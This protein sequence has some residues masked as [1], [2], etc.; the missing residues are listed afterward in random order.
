MHW[1]TTCQ[2]TLNV[3][4]LTLFSLLCQYKDMIHT[5]REINPVIRYGDLYRLWDPF[6]VSVRQ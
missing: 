6:K 4:T 2:H 5:F 1:H 3:H